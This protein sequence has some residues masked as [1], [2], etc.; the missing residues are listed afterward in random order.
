M[1]RCKLLD[2]VAV[3]KSAGLRLARQ[4][5]A[6]PD[7]AQF[8]NCPMTRSWQAYVCHPVYNTR[9]RPKGSK[10]NDSGG[11]PHRRKAVLGAN[12]NRAGAACR[13]PGQQGRRTPTQARSLAV[14]P[15][16]DDV[17][18]DLDASFQTIS[19]ATNTIPVTV[20]LSGSPSM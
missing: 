5:A 10:S 16:L 13:A 14:S 20:V 4:A 1:I 11:S 7:L 3:P 9:L 8:P 12:R 17:S 18:S 19:R 2:S 6:S 15:S